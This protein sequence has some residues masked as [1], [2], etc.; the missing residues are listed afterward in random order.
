MISLF[1]SEQGEKTVFFFEADADPDP[2]PTFHPDT[3]PDLYPDP[4]FQIKAHTL[5]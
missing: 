2:D 4:S 5:E 1:H 3:D